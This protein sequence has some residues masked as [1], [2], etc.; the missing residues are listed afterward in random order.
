[1]T[2][3]S[4]EIAL[5][6]VE[7][8][9][10]EL[11]KQLSEIE[12]KLTDLQADG[13]VRKSRI[14]DLV[15]TVNEIARKGVLPVNTSEA[16]TEQAM[17]RGILDR[18][19]IEGLNLGQ[20]EK[21]TEAYSAF[22]D[23]MISA[24]NELELVNAAIR[25]IMEHEQERA[26]LA[27]KSAVPG[28]QPVP[29]SPLGSSAIIRSQEVERQRIAR[30]IHDGPAQAI[31]NVVLRMDIVLKI[32]EKDPSKVPDELAKM[33]T[34]AQGALDEIRGFIFDLRPMTLQDLGLV[35][36]IKR[37]VASL[38]DLAGID[39]RFIVEGLE[40]PLGQLV[41]L[42]VFRIAQE[43]LNNVRK[44]SNCKTAWIHL[45]FQPDQV[46]LIVEDD[47]VGFDL[48]EVEQNQKKYIS[49]GLLGMHE[50]AEDI[51]A[52][53]QITSAVGEGTKVA[54]VVPVKNNPA[55]EEKSSQQAKDPA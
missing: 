52:D 23:K 12:R 19:V 28:A 35:A 44:S 16:E 31:A 54:L 27:K 8:V 5:Q 17:L 24:I 42:A 14:E 53:L 15:S 41:T 2:P 9:G 48:N 20:N 21:L 13:I 36:T 26:E 10:E 39:V 6:R 1:M 37:V 7:Q 47:G 30:E 22:R 46:I 11:R 49:F 51:G 33:K 55:V 4:S 29:R 50:R 32:Y 3:S 38:K 34:I 25:K 45:K 40:R 18:V 43:A